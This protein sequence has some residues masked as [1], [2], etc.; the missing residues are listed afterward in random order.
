M[1]Y[2]ILSTT[3][4]ERKKLIENGE[5]ADVYLISNSLRSH[6]KLEFFIPKSNFSL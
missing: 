6:F 3:G 1:Q 4:N 2:R 5:R